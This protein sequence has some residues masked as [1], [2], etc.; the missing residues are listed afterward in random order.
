MIP[1][2]TSTCASPL[3]PIRDEPGQDGQRRQHCEGEELNV[4]QEE[5][6]A[7]AAYGRHQ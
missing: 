2:A 7:D 6:E 4:V 1:T 5:G 3:P